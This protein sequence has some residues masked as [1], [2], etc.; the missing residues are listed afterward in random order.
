MDNLW[1]RD[2]K[3]DCVLCK[4]DDDEKIERDIDVDVINQYRQFS[5]QSLAGFMEVD[6]CINSFYHVT[7][8]IC[9]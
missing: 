6:I 7:N 5:D 3:I 2:C 1:C 9:K 8:L 4:N